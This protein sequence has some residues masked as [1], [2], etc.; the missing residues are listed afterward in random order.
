MD[1][2]PA[3]FRPRTTRALLGAPITVRPSVVIPGNVML[4]L[5]SARFPFSVA[6][7]E[8]L[9]RDLLAAAAFVRSQERW[10]KER[11]R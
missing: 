6:K 1:S 9:A 5:D 10:R 2:R 7:A 4:L 3:K 8:K 11:A